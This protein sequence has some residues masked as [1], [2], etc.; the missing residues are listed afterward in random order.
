MP[1]PGFPIHPDQS[2]RQA[3]LEGVPVR[4]DTLY[5]NRLGEEK[6]GIRKRA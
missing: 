6:Q 1:V 5:S 2:A 3:S 4:E